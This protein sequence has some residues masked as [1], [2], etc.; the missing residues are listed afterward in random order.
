[1]QSTRKRRASAR[2]TVTLVASLAVVGCGEG[3]DDFR[4][5]SIPGVVYDRAGDP[6]EI[7]QKNRTTSRMSSS[8]PYYNRAAAEGGRIV[9]GE[10]APTATSKI[11]RSGF[12]ASASRFVS[13]F[14]GGHSSGG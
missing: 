8:H 13:G 3:W 6:Y 14:S 2:V 11:A 7:D 4:H 9:R 12:G 5:G 10:T 1:M